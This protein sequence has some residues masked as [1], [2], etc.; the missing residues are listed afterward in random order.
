MNQFAR[1]VFRTTLL[2]LL[3]GSVC[4]LVL[5]P[6]SF[7]QVPDST[8][9]VVG[10]V[11]DSLAEAD[12]LV[13]SDTVAVQAV[14]RAPLAE[15]PE[16]DSYVVSD[17]TSFA[18]PV[19]RAELNLP[20][21]LGSEAGVF[22]FEFGTLGWPESVSIEGGDPN[23]T[24]LLLDG[25]EMDDLITGRPR[26]ELLPYA[27][28]QS[29]GLIKSGAG[30]ESGVAA[31]TNP[32]SAPTPQ[33]DLRYRSGANGL[34]YIDAVHVQNRSLNSLGAGTKLQ[35]LASYSGSA[36]TGDYPGSRLETARQLQGRIRLQRPGWSI[37][38]YEL[39]NKHLVGAHGGVHATNDIY[40][41]IYFRFGATVDDVN[42]QR[43]TIRNDLRLTYRRFIASNPTTVSAGWSTQRLTFADGG[44]KDSVDIRVSRF[45]ASF[46]QPVDVG[47]HAFVIDLFAS[48]DQYVGGRAANRPEDESR[49]RYDLVLRD[50]FIVKGI[51]VNTSLGAHSDDGRIFPSALAK[52]GLRPV[53]LSATYSGIRSQ[54]FDVRGLGTAFHP[55]KKK[56]EINQL[57]L[58]VT[59][60]QA[61][62]SGRLT[63][64]GFYINTDSQF[65]LH[66]GSQGANQAG[67][68][69]AYTR[70][71]GYLDLTFSPSGVGGLYGSVK[72]TFIAD[73]SPNKISELSTYEKSMPGFWI[74]GRIGIRRLLFKGDMNLDFSVRGSWSES[75]RGRVLDQQS[76]LLFLQDFDALKLDAAPRLDLV[77][78][79][80]IKSATL[81]FS[82]ENFLYGNNTG[83]GISFVPYYPVPARRFRFG[84]FWPIAD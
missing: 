29:V 11:P 67:L 2:I 60:T 83:T 68:T 36:H 16:F 45:S 74:E 44:L 43:G 25:L 38:L 72:P 5:G 73:I 22:H 15:S 35:L 61:W 62:E 41:S 4:G 20:S 47:N 42:A 10:A 13:A 3:I 49:Y 69:D 50:S 8:R 59:V 18:R 54:W 81:F 65:I 46:R 80:G 27:T 58:A 28:L 63:L 9:I 37:E 32:Y 75:M 66:Q 71:G 12:I 53:S 70:A 77:A 51:G 30:F 33:T 26:Y 31:Y 48:T 82:Y 19:R 1:G 79:A 78:E 6:S 56:P 24:M 55:L 23:R 21:L 64:T 39:Y 17:S 14:V 52:F 34:T 40:D 7:A 84:L 76:G 57:R